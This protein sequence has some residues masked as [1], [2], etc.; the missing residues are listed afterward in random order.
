M[1]RHP[2]RVILNGGMTAR[3][4]ELRMTKLQ[5]GELGDVGD[6]DGEGACGGVDGD[7]TLHGC[8]VSPA[9]EPRIPVSIGVGL[10]ERPDL[11]GNS[12]S[13]VPP[14]RAD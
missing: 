2:G 1:A 8:P 12:R 9:V 13:I 5:E 14:R 6:V 7:G 11:V 4:N 3:S 10:S